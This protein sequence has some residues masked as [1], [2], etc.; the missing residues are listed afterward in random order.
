MVIFCTLVGV[1]S[2]IFGKWYIQED[3][4]HEV[5]ESGINVRI[6]VRIS[7]VVIKTLTDIA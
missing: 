6:N 7:K 1:T 5:Q 2:L 3:L 4:V